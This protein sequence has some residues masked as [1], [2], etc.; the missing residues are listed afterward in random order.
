MNAPLSPFVVGRPLKA[1]EPL[2]GREETFALIHAALSRFESI[3]LVGE[4]RMGK[5]SFFN[6][7]LNNPQYSLA[8]STP[9][10]LL[11]RVDLQHIT[12]ARRF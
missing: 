3:N 2:F 8:P 1:T 6:H 12:D 9:P 5:T 10:L 11:I 7:L 4:R